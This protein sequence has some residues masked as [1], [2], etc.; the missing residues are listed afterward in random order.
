MPKRLHLEA[1]QD[2]DNKIKAMEKKIKKLENELDEMKTLNIF[3]QREHFSLTCPETKSHIKQLML[4]SLSTIAQDSCMS[5]SK[6][7]LSVSS[8]CTASAPVSSGTTTC[9]VSDVRPSACVL[10]DNAE[11]I[12]FESSNISTRFDIESLITDSELQIKPIEITEYNITD[13]TETQQPTATTLNEIIKTV[14]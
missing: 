3:Y 4:S 8:K 11:Y 2:K 10:P 14:R 9:T 13:T 1:I 6:T 7:S 12:T 5:S